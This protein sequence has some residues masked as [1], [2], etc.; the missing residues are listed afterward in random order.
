MLTPVMP[1]PM[2]AM[3]HDEGR[4]SEE[5]K[6]SIGCSSERQ[7]DEVWFGSGKPLLFPDWMFSSSLCLA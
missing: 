2:I 5:Q 6:E 4:S 1:A 3:S 7:Y